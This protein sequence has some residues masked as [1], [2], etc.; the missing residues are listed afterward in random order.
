MAFQPIENYGI[1]GDSP[2]SIPTILHISTPV[3]A[4]DGLLPGPAPV[5][6]HKM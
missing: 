6:R 1:I 4:D 2:K 5:A 3:W